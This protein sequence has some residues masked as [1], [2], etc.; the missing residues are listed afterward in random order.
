MSGESTQQ[1][2]EG[3]TD[4]ATQANDFGEYTGKA[5]GWVISSYC[6]N[7]SCVVARKSPENPG[8]FEIADRDDN[9]LLGSFLVSQ[10]SY[11][12]FIAG[13]RAGEFDPENI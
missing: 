2:F 7:S 8:Y 11:G 13:V 12:A 1:Q 6:G 3:A 4:P 5:G 10:E 9:R